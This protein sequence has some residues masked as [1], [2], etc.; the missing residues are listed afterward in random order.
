LIIDDAR[1]RAKCPAC[2]AYGLFLWVPS[3]ELIVPAASV[4]IGIVQESEVYAALGDDGFERLVAEFYQ[5][6]PG[7]EVLGPMYA[8]KDLSGAQRRLRGFLI[9]RFGGPDHYLEERGHPRLRMRHAPFAVNDLARQHW[10]KLMRAALENAGIDPDA[11]DTLWNYFEA[12]ATAMI[13]QP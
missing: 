11:K 13:N 10:L 7:D 8:G 9:Y 6:V 12:T 3:S 5:Q 1:L 4:R 2:F